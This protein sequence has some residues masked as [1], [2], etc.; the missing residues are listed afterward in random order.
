MS[1][2]E[3]RAAKKEQKGRVETVG[4][5]ALSPPPGE[6]SESDLSDNSASSECTQS[7]TALGNRD[8]RSNLG[9][10]GKNRRKPVAL[11]DYKKEI[12][13]NRYFSKVYHSLYNYVNMV[14]WSL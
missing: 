10:Q 7:D 3:I 1:A 8:K 11:P 2:A 12:V 4:R 13:S 5:R 14:K 6:I 9:C